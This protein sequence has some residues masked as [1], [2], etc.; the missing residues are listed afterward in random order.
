VENNQL[1]DIYSHYKTYIT[2]QEIGKTQSTLYT[3]HGYK[4]ILEQI[5]VE[6]DVTTFSLNNNRF[7]IETGGLVQIQFF[8]YGIFVLLLLWAP[9]SNQ[10]IITAEGIFPPPGIMLFFEEGWLDNS[11]P[12]I[13]QKK[14]WCLEEIEWQADEYTGL[15]QDEASTQEHYANITLI[16]E[17]MK[18]NRHDCYTVI[19]PDQTAYSWGRDDAGY[20]HCP[21][22]QSI[23]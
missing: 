2:D 20:I 18:D 13:H 1:M 8:D 23:E 17:M 10:F 11:I 22:I 6:E 16:D 12:P 19:F 4:L 9:H 3:D 7:Q 14:D 5:S 15:I 21:M